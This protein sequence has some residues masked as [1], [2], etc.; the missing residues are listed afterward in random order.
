MKNEVAGGVIAV[1]I[2]VAI[3]M[4]ASRKRTS[5]ANPKDE[6]KGQKGVEGRKRVISVQRFVGV[7]TAKSDWTS[8]KGC[9]AFC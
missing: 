4:I 9:I 3:V 7:V 1:I 8:G 5:H 2:C 6:A